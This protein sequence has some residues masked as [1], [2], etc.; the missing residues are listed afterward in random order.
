MFF[1][2]YLR[3][4]RPSLDMVAGTSY[5]QGAWLRHR[6]SC[7]DAEPQHDQ[8]VNNKWELYSVGSGLSKRK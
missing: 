1:Y 8:K 6:V 4:D 3:F 7:R 2:S 5:V